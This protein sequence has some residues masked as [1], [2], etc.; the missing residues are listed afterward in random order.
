M[1]RLKNKL[2][3]KKVLVA[4][5]DAGGAD[6]ISSWLFISKFKGFDFYLI[7]PS[8]KIF[9]S[10]LKKINRKKKIILK[11][12]DL[13]ITGSSLKSSH[14][15]NIIR[16]ANKLNI[17]VITFMDHWV[18]YKKRFLRRKKYFLPDNFVVM[19]ICAKKIAQKNFINK[20]IYLIENFRKKYF[21]L[22]YKNYTKLVKKNEYL[23]FSSNYDLI[24]KKSDLKIL[25]RFVN[26]LKKR[27]IRNY[28]IY[29]KN[30]PSEKNNKYN[31][32]IDN[33]KYFKDKSKNIYECISNYHNFFASESMGLVYAKYGKKNIYNLR[34]K[35]VEKIPFEVLGN[36]FYLNNN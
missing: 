9:Q 1:V 28:K 33:K 12:Y 14:E 8:V 19:D 34:T 10:K 16:K 29:I 18:N 4:C 7:G 21:D 13:I 23:Y 17:P 11:K 36:N 27:K 22:F 20:K 35:N 32:I 3:N 6:V 26:E 30:H 2:K 31:F 24:K 5:C 15:I 25:M